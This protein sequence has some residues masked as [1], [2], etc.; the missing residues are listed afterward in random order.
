MHRSEQI[1]AVSHR[2]RTKDQ[3]AA[4]CADVEAVR[5]VICVIRNGQWEQAQIRLVFRTTVPNGT[6][7]Y[8]MK[9][10][11][12]TERKV[13]KL[14]AAGK[15]E[16]M[17]IQIQ[18]VEKVCQRAELFHAKVVKWSSGEGDAEKDKNC[19][20]IWEEALR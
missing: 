3:R 16:L 14:S 20:G 7:L 17:R 1:Q 5:G 13:I 8:H 19:G 4:H 6:A 15:G 2:L 10:L 12:G 9:T 18:P 11:S